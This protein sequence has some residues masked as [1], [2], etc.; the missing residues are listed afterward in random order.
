MATLFD[1]TRDVETEHA[2][3]CNG[4]MHNID[5]LK[6][7]KTFYVCGHCGF[8]TDVRLPLCPLCRVAHAPDGVD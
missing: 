7:P 5:E 6:S 1:T 2:N 3:L 4:A 8:T